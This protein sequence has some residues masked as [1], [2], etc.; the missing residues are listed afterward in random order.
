MFLVVIVAISYL[1][2]FQSTV[3]GPHTTLF[4]SSQ[5][6][7]VTFPLYKESTENFLHT[8]CMV[9]IL[10]IYLNREMT[11]CKRV[12]KIGVIH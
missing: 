6:V 2:I 11:H 9:L 3:D 1:L 4:S 10:Y 12:I 5:M 8:F 7:Q